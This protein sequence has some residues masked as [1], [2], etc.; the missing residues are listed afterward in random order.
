M[1]HVANTHKRK[2]ANIALGFAAFSV[3]FLSVALCCYSYLWGYVCEGLLNKPNELPNYA[4]I[5]LKI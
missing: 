4:E 5:A 2:T 3:C 1:C